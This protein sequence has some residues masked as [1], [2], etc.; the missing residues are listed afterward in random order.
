MSEEAVFL[1][2]HAFDGKSLEPLRRCLDEP[3]LDAGA[4]AALIE[5]C[6]RDSEKHQVG[7]TWL[8]KAHLERGHRLTASA[9]A[10]FVAARATLTAWEARLHACQLVRHLEVAAV[11]LGPLTRFLDSALEGGRPFLRAWACDALV[12][13]ADRHGRLREAAGRALQVAE[14]DPAASVRAR[15]RHLRK[16]HPAL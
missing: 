8:L 6:A 13:L 14:R 16:D 7:A 1:A 15:A 4:I 9:V 3:G 2:L 12:H 10:D 5:V 11:D